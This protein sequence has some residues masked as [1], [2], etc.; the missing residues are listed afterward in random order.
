MYKR[1]GI[2][3]YPIF[4]KNALFFLKKICNSCLKNRGLSLKGSFSLSF[5][6]P[7]QSN[8]KKNSTYKPTP[9]HILSGNTKV[10]TSEYAIWAYMD[11]KHR[12]SSLVF[13]VSSYI[14]VL[15][16]TTSLK[17]KLLTEFSCIGACG[18]DV[19][20]ANKIK[21]PYH[22][23]GLMEACVVRIPWMNHFFAAVYPDQ[24]EG[25]P[26]YLKGVLKTTFYLSPL[27]N[28]IIQA[29]RNS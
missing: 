14:R 11:F 25:L 26:N 13:S 8:N 7:F 21:I 16:C 22:W 5:L 1:R 23:V 19:R 10:S 27:R 24:Q 2:G 15:R 17:S 20:M 12:V 4:S 9:R 28:S 6:Q 3:Q 29:I 18:C